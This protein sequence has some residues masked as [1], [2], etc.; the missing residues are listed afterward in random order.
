MNCSDRILPCFPERKYSSSSSNKYSFSDLVDISVLE[1]L[2]KSFFEATGISHGLNDIHDNIICAVGWQDICSKFHRACIHTEYNCRQSNRYISNHL[3]DGPYVGS[4]CLN[5]LMDYA[6]PIVIDGQHLATIYLGQVFHTPPDEDYFKQQALR[7]GFDVESYL[8]A[9]AKVPVISRKEILLYISCYSKVAHLLGCI[10]LER[11]IQRENANRSIHKSEQDY[12]HALETISDGFWHWDI[13]KDEVLVN[14]QLASFLN[15]GSEEITMDFNSWAGFLHPQDKIE[16]MRLLKDHLEEKTSRF[17]MEHRVS[18]GKGIYKWVLSRGK[19]LARS[20]KGRP[21][22]MVS[23]C[24]DI[25]HRKQMENAVRASEEKFAKAFNASPVTMSITTLHEGRIMAV[26]NSFC[27]I[28]GYE[29]EEILGRTSLEIGFWIRL[30]D[31]NEIVK[32]ILDHG[33]VHPKEINFRKRSGVQRLGVYSA[34]R[35]SIEGTTCILTLLEDITERHQMEIDML[36]MDRLNIVGEMAASIGHEIRNPMTSIRG[37]LQMFADKYRDDEEFLNIMIGE[38]DRAN[39]I[40]TEFLSL[41]KNKIVELVPSRLNH[42]LENICPLLKAGAAMQEKH[43]LLDLA[44]DLPLLLLDDKEIRQMLLNLVNNGLEAMPAGGVLTI[45][46]SHYDNLVAL[47]IQD[48]GGGIDSDC[49]SKLGTPFYTTKENGTGLGLPIC[50]TI[51]ARH[52][53]KIEVETSPNGTNFKVFFPAA[54]EHSSL[55]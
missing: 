17:E 11:I 6:T 51:A 21:L 8:E 20:V 27:R 2:M 42:I 40:I 25:S 22:R 9:L 38:L 47:S 15:R 31:R 10:G 53:A 13:E 14:A 54:N 37:F 52:K 28:L 32:A 1:S 35:L 19:V 3:F 24:L 29:K 16:T 33:S 23:A 44:D 55:F 34:E 30:E 48:Q 50:Y 39:L 4:K 7:Y 45:S 36:R 26:N 41:A 46:T 12:T 5:G 18:A 49:F 43:I